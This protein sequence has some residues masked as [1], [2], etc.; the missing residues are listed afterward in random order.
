MDV[1]AVVG[2]EHDG[3]VLRNDGGSALVDRFHPLILPFEDSVGLDGEDLLGGR[4]HIIDISRYRVDGGRRTAFPALA[5]VE[6]PLLGAGRVVER[7]EL[8]AAAVGD[9]IDRR[10][11]GGID[12]TGIAERLCGRR[13]PVFVE[14]HIGRCR[15][16]DFPAHLLPVDGGGH[17]D[18]NLDGGI[19]RDGQVIHFDRRGHHG[20]FQRPGRLPLLPGPG[21]VRSHAPD[22][23]VEGQRHRFAGDD[24]GLVDGLGIGGGKRDILLGGLLAYGNFRILPFIGEDDFPRTLRRVFIGGGRERHLGISVAGIR[25]NRQPLGT[26]DGPCNIG[27]DLYRFA[28]ACGHEDGG[29]PVKGKSSCRPGNLLFFLLFVTGETRGCHCRYG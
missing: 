12:R 19:V 15:H 28:P 7:I 13:P 8:G 22:R 14:E 17:G 5:R 3:A 26:A 4:G 20:T 1:R 24:G 6:L 16:L 2:K 18:G 27:S 11:V 9:C 25:G 23:G 29:V 21:D 10:L